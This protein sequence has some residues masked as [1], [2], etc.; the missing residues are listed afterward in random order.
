MQQINMPGNHRLRRTIRQRL[1]SAALAIAALL[2]T[3]SSANAALLTHTFGISGDNGETGA[4]TFTWDD[5]V[6][7]N[8]SPVS[9]S[10]VDLGAILSLS[11]EISGGNII[12]GTTVFTGSD[13]VGA[14]LQD[15]P[16]FLTDINV[17]CN[18]GVNT[19]SGR[20]ENVNYLN[21]TVDF[22]AGLTQPILGPSSSTLTFSPG[23]TRPARNAGAYSIPTTPWWALLGLGLLMVVV[24]QRSRQT[25][26][27]VFG[28]N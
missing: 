17:F 27:S 21:D 25:A 18:N 20:T 1:S 4:G 28:L 10:L 22:G 16:D 8:G 26:E 11:I 15:S 14:Y 3:I 7:G 5:T 24:A 2:T 9:D 23:V 12:G 19:L 6:V 13:C